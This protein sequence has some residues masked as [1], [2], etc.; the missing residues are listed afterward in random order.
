MGLLQDAFIRNHIRS[1][2]TLVVSVG[3]ND[4]ALKPSVKTAISAL[5]M[6][7]MSSVE[8]IQQGKASGQGH[9]HSLFHTETKRYV[10]KLIARTKPKRVIIC[11]L[12]FLDEAQTGSWADRVLGYLGYNDDPRRLQAAIRHVFDTATSRIQIEGVEVIPVPLFHALDGKT[13]ADYESRVE[14]SVIGGEKM[15][16]LLTDAI[17]N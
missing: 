14:P 6:S 15:A 3:G 13:S 5:T 10:E 7:R 8:R 1:Q 12:Y 11:T 16:R 17:L 2:D 9:F 4:V